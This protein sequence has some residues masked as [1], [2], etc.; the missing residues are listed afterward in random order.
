MD[1]DVHG[2]ATGSEL[3][4]HSQAACYLVSLQKHQR[5]NFCDLQEY[6]KV[7]DAH[8]ALFNFT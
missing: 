3:P 5:Q 6:K 1:E 8:K 2:A 4:G 7:L